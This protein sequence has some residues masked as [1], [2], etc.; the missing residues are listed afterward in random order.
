[1]RIAWVI[2]SSASLTKKETESRG[3]YFIP[4]TLTIDGKEYRDGVD[5]F[6]KEYY[7]MIK[8]EM[9]VK[10][11]AASPAVIEDM[12][13]K[14]SKEYDQVVIYPLSAGLSS[15]TNTI[16]VMSKEY[17]NVNCIYSAGVGSTIVTDIELLEEMNKNGATIEEILAKGKEITLSSHGVLLTDAMDWLVK[18]GRISPK[19]AAMAKMLKIIPVISWT[20]DGKLDKF[21][22][23]R[24]FRKTLLKSV[25]TLMNNE[26]D[27]EN[28]TWTIYNGGNKNIKEY[29]KEIE[30]IIGTKPEITWFPPIIGI[31]T[32]PNVVGVI[33][34]KKNT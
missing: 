14:L 27:L 33:L 26:K 9:D 4:L 12:M 28:M 1:M 30:E 15:I 19:A 13:I 23:G 22:K 11:S 16:T 32:G 17:D 31:H 18:G 29:A 8:I 5:I 25:K 24:T 10:T 7:E 20:N 34:H 21:G 3:W 6:A 2:D